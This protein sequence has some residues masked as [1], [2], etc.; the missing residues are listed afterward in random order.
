MSQVSNNQQR[1]VAA[2]SAERVQKILIIEADA[3]KQDQHHAQ[4]P[5]QKQQQNQGH[6]RA[7]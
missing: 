7:P 1:T 2:F 4:Q 6:C 3:T 5:D